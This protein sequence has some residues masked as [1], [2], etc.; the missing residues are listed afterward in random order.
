[1]QIE[2]HAL[3][4]PVVRLSYGDD[5]AVV[6]LCGGH[7]VAW[8][9]RGRDMLWCTTTRLE[10]KPLRGGIPVCWPWFGAHP[11]DLLKPAHGL[12]R[13]RPWSFVEHAASSVV[14][15]TAEGSLT[16]TIAVALGDAL[17]V[18]LT[19]RNDGAADVTLTAALHT[20]FAVDDIDQVSVSGLNSASYIDT[21]DGWTKKSQQG[22]LRFEAEVDRIYAAGG[23]TLRD[24][25]RTVEI[26]SE[27]TSRS[28]VAWN[29]W[30]A[31]SARLGDIAPG[32]YRRMVC[33]ETAW[34]ADDA[35]TLPAGST[36]TLTTVL[37]PIAS[38]P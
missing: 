3:A 37:R 17:R 10:G 11:T 9:H 2:E 12:V 30:I 5:T 15:T 36:A 33:L 13:N 4:G 26:D 6:A 20:Y 25:S 1:M 28:L 18:S 21:L 35:R 31:K 24:K 29:P 7:V 14:M 34:A 32:E 27:G 16:A 38:P 22:Y 23:A 8:R 19:T